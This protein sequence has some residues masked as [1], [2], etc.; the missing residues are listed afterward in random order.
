M[1][2]K[3]HLIYTVLSVAAAVLSFLKLGII[4]SILPSEQFGIY[5]LVMLSFVYIGYIGSIG[6]NE[7]MLKVGAINSGSDQQKLF[8]ILK[9]ALI[10]GFCGVLI[11]C[12]VVGVINYY[13]FDETI[14][15]FI[16]AML[17][18]AL[19][20][21]PYNIFESYYRSQ[22]KIYI[23]SGMLFSKAILVL[24]F[25]YILIDDFGSLG[26]IISEIF[27]LL[28]ISLFF[29]LKEFQAILKSHLD[30]PIKAIKDILSNGFHV[31]MSNFFR[32]FALTADRY[33]VVLI[34]G[35]YHVGI[36]SFV[37]IFYQGIVLLTGILMNVLGPKM[38]KQYYE[39]GSIKH[40]LNQLKKISFLVCA[41][42]LV[43]YPFFYFILPEVVQ[44]FFK[45]YDFDVVYRSFYIVYWVSIISFLI[46]LF[47]WFFICVSKENFISTL[48]L[49]S[50][51]LIACSALVFKLF[52]FDFLNYLLFFLISK[53]TIFIIMLSLVLKLRKQNIS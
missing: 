22:Q 21:Y 3:A 18:L 16:Y 20:T 33:V 47:D 29:I 45:Q 7:Y 25:I 49:L 9:N 28:F 34:F 42:A 41:G 15:N 4:A 52:N 44:L 38:I 13:L 14:I 6:S 31:C 32:N 27:S 2:Q 1:F 5:S 30:P 17:A 19:V 40:L 11:V 35:L 53:V 24:L 43:F 12:S 10:Y 39:K 51:V 50:L 37:M 48:S 36:Y 26:A 46:F 8:V 23:F